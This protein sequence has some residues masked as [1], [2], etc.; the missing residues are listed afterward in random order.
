MEFRAI[1]PLHLDLILTDFYVM[2][3][4][5]QVRDVT[6]PLYNRRTGSLKLEPFDYAENVLFLPDYTPE[7]RIEAYAVLGGMPPYLEQFDSQ[8]SLDENLLETALRR[9]TYLNEE[10]DWLLLEDLRRAASGAAMLL[11]TLLSCRVH[12]RTLVARAAT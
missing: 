4:E 6:A 2:F 8:R 3:M 12:R 5:R 9:N 1:P 11:G 10:P 7:E